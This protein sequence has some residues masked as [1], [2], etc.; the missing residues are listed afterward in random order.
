MDWAQV[1]VIILAILFAVFLL[2]GIVLV[3]MLIKIT[4]QIKSVTGSAQRTAENVEHTVAGL[5]KVSS[6][7]FFVRMASKFFRKARR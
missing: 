7:L 5:S 1:L 2:L 4:K 3:T 6:P